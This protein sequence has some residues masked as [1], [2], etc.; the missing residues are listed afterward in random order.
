[1]EERLQKLIAHAGIASRRKAEELIQLGQVTVNGRVAKL[2]DKADLAHDSV[3]VSGKRLNAKPSQPIYLA[4]NK[5]KGCISTTDDPE[6]RRTVLDLLPAR[7]RNKVY[8]VG[9]LD[10]NSEG[11]MLLTNDGDFA[12]HIL[13]E[14]SA[15]PKTYQV[16]VTGALNKAQL[17]KFREGVVVDGRKTAP[18]KIRMVRA[19]ENPWYEVVLHE[20]RNRQIRKMF[21]RL[22]PMVEKIKRTRIGPLALGRLPL[23][24][25]RPLTP[26][27]IERFRKAWS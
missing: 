14:K 11:L 5:P 17:E 1:M 20:G 23:G 6:G 13:A 4:L 19:G 7:L 2:G 9:R 26:R 27:E 10:Y 3:K 24:E 15:L 18:A 25:S 8:P 22:G 21:H 16:K 12:A